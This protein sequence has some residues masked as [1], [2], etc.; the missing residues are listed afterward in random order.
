MSWK[1]RGFG[2]CPRSGTR[3]PRLPRTWR[4][5]RSC[6]QS[7]TLWSWIQKSYWIQQERKQLRGQQRS[8]ARR[9]ASRPATM[10]ALQQRPECASQPSMHESNTA[11]R[12]L[13]SKS[14][15]KCLSEPRLTYHYERGRIRKTPFCTHRSFAHFFLQCSGLDN[16]YRLCI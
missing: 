14:P 16:F 7:C 4:S 9:G 11:P 1:S 12:L 15:A 2:G 3:W 5:W 10:Y 6:C 13:L 8:R